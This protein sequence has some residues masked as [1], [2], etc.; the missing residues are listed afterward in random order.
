MT[1]QE[2]YKILLVEDGSIDVDELEDF[3]SES[4]LRIPNLPEVKLIINS[5][6]NWKL[7]V[8]PYQ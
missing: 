4:S 3:I 5:V 8:C 1:E 2:Q 7:I 6:V